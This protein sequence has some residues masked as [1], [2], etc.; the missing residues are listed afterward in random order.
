MYLLLEQE[1]RSARN[2]YEELKSA[3][4]KWSIKS[5]AVLDDCFNIDKKRVVEFCKLIKP[6]KLSWSCANG[7]R[8]DRLDE[9][10]A[11]AM[12]ASGC[13]QAS[14]GI[15][16]VALEVLETIRKGETIEEVERAVDIAKRY[17]K[18]VS[19]FF[20]IGLPKSS[21][22]RDLSSLEGNKRSF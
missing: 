16:S 3:K 1:E 11:K 20:I 8:A 7:L 15:E 2:C 12:A 18:S 13:E 17:F 9:D 4:K 19:G 14:F 6:L 10:M 22:E 21:Y 5:F